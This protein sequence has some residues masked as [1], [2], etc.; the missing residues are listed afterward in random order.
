MS[1]SILFPT[2]EY[3][4]GSKVLPSYPELRINPETYHA[5]L[6]TNL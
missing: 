1:S 5:P 2:N 6:P 4:V 3:A